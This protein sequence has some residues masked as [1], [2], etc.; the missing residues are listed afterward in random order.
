MAANYR[1]RI[2]VPEMAIPAS[3]E[4]FLQENRGGGDQPSHREDHG[5]FGRVEGGDLPVVPEA[6]TLS[7]TPSLGVSGGER[8]GFGFQLGSTGH[9]AGSLFVTP[10]ALRRERKDFDAIAATMDHTLRTG[11]KGGSKG[12]HQ[13][14][15]SRRRAEAQIRG[16]ASS[17]SSSESDGDVL[18]RFANDGGLRHAMSSHSKEEA[19]WNRLLGLGDVDRVIPMGDGGLDEEQRANGLRPHHG[20]L[21]LVT[22]KVDRLALDAARSRVDRERLFTANEVSEAWAKERRAKESDAHIVSPKPSS[23]DAT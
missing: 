22:T 19:K 20:K 5:Q 7:L 4:R 18:G 13:K 9:R 6:A 23:M 8:D 15:L 21:P 3:V 2:L 12:R 1:S 17:S 16:R 11:A 14:K 10:A